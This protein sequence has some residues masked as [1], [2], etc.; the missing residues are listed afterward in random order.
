MRI[1]SVKAGSTPKPELPAFYF[2]YIVQNNFL[3]QLVC[4]HN[5][6][7]LWLSFYDSYAPFYKKSYA[8]CLPRNP[9]PSYG[10]ESQL[11]NIPSPLDK[12]PVEYRYHLRNNR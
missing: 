7:V 3:S 8:P 5:L 2:H 9:S 1:I 11:E 10:F 12:I 4:Q 6:S